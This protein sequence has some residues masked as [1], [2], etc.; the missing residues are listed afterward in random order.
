MEHFY[1]LNDRLDSLLGRVEYMEYDEGW[2]YVPTSASPDTQTYTDLGNLTVD[3]EIFAVRRRDDDGSNHYD[4]TSG[5]NDGYG[6]SVSGSREPRSREQHVVAIR[7]FLA[8]IDPATGY[9]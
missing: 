7:D 5:P 8:A 3:G 9:L 2:V 4:W 1:K 6:F